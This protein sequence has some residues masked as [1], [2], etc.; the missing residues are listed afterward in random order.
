MIISPE[1]KENYCICGQL[2]SGDIERNEHILSHF[3]QKHCSGCDVDL[4]FVAGKWYQHHVNSRCNFKEDPDYDGGVMNEEFVSIITVEPQVKCESI[5]PSTPIE[6][7]SKIIDPLKGI[8]P[9][10]PKAVPNES[11]P[12]LYEEPESEE[13]E[14]EFCTDSANE[15]TDD[16]SDSSSSSGSDD[17]DYR[18]P[19]KRR[20][21]NIVG[22][23]SQQLPSPPEVLKE[24]DDQAD[25]AS[26]ELEFK[27]AIS[28]AVSD[29]QSIDEKNSKAS[30]PNE[31][32]QIMWQCQICSKS[33]SK[34]FTAYKH[35]RDRHA[36]NDKTKAIPVPYKEPEETK[37]TDSDVK[38]WKC[39]LCT[40]ERQNKCNMY[41]HIRVKH[42]SND[43]SLAIPAP[44]IIKNKML[45]KDIK[46]WKCGFCSVLSKE[47]GNMIKHLR[48][49][50]A[51]DDRAMVI[52]APN[53]NKDRK[54]GKMFKCGICSWLS[55]FRAGII[56]HLRDKHASDDRSMVLLAPNAKKVY[57]KDIKSWK[58][59]ICSLVTVKKYSMYEHIRV[60][61]ESNDMTKAIPVPYSSN[62]RDSDKKLCETGLASL[63]VTQTS[64]LFMPT[65]R[66]RAVKERVANTTM[67]KCGI[68]SA[69]TRRKQSMHRHL[70]DK[71]QSFDN[72]LVIP[73]PK[74]SRVPAS[75]VMLWEC[76][77]CTKM[78]I[79]KNSMLLHIQ[80]KHGLD[81]AKL[82]MLISNNIDGKRPDDAD[83]WS[84]GFCAY[85]SVVKANAE[86][87]LR[88]MHESDDKTMET[89]LLNQP[90]P[91]KNRYN[92][93]LCAKSFEF[94][95]LL[96]KHM[97]T[98]QNVEYKCCIDG[99]EE[100]FDSDDSLLD[101]L[102]GHLKAVC[103][104]CQKSYIQL[105]HIVHKCLKY[106][107]HIC[108]YCGKI[109]PEKY[110]LMIHVNGHTDNRPYSCD[111]CG[112]AY[113]R[114]TQLTQHRHT[115]TGTKPFSCNVPNCDR[116]F[117]Q[118]T[119]LY[120]HQFK[121]HGIYKKKHPCTL[122]D[123]VFPENALLRKHMDNHAV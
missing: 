43:K 51:S 119:D 68:C 34:S 72:T 29:V 1:M 33:Y 81:D 47:R 45:F 75:G 93:Y 120:R 87:H 76:S 52:P 2:V 36:T 40:A 10:V 13:E 111:V 61:H 58:C 54:S 118:R 53:A 110:A 122:C 60:K 94:P 108:D 82:A 48:I 5:E 79:T 16:L 62:V 97:Q 42:G 83:M 100:K 49:Q 41:T 103:K 112:K 14:E 117:I 38:R 107:Q 109:F 89:M 98:H 27:G 44:E 106:K 50:H 65:R 91:K 63:M 115:H 24:I 90:N 8:D 11:L 114:P 28:D 23:T 6:S 35:L 57:S 32:D 64:N 30:R 56:R 73:I 121:A 39:T 22:E 88:I 96:T 7:C 105:P 4:I 104:N 18:P 101:H 86:K 25:D 92:C 99:C 70:R 80:V 9:I 69:I 85:E 46:M 67:W 20:T 15:M 116:A 71:H 3:E 12:E 55:K 84:C 31:A 74:V 66:I 37:S 21:S 77:I 26:D 123:Q 95:K 113:R 19:T 59:G 78:C 102:K 17:E